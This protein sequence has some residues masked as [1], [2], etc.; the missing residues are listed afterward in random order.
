M[1]KSRHAEGRAGGRGPREAG[2]KELTRIDLTHVLLQH[3]YL[4]DRVN[5]IECVGALRTEANAGWIYSR[6]GPRM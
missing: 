6:P 5:Q 3:G 1:S 2:A 4:V